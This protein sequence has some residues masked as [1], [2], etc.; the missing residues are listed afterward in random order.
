MTARISGRRRVS[1]LR[2]L[3]CGFF[4]EQYPRYDTLWEGLSRLGF[5]Q[6]IDLREKHVLN[7]KY[8]EGTR[9]EAGRNS[10]HGIARR[11]RTFLRL[12]RY[13]ISIS[14]AAR[15]KKADVIF[16]FSDNHFLAICLG[17]LK[18]FH[19]A[20]VY[21][22]L[23]DPIYLAAKRNSRG[24]FKIVESYVLEFLASRLADRLLC[25][26][27]ECATY[28]RDQYRV[29][30]DKLSVVPDG[31]QGIWFDEPA[32]IGH[33]THRPRRVLYWGMFLPH[34]GLDMILDA[35][36]ELRDENIEF[37]FCGTGDK[38]EWLKEEIRRRNL[39]NVVFKGFIPT[40]REL[41]HI[42]NGVDVTLGALRDVPALKLAPLNR[43]RQAMARGKPVITI[44]TRQQEDFY[45]T[46]TT[47]FP[48]LI[49]IEPDVESLVRAIVD[50]VNSPE[51]AERIGNIAR[52]T[53]RRLHGI[54]AITSALGKSFEKALEV[55][56]RAEGD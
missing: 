28:Y 32:S 14:Q 1:D 39:D 42:I 38:E 2:V 47:P 31:V 21:F 5:Q 51:K 12:C 3:V 16:V 54:E 17:M 30:D 29:R 11:T 18:F 8:M 23:F 9:S 53:A 49:L 4:L 48:P 43:V 46:K 34:H 6:L 45:Q 24:R 41:I 37:I 40:T 56:R 55:G 25:F 52:S 20:W 36:E 33:E 19:S 26:T 44:W 13:A 22:D 7:H 35:A 27:P 10:F 15:H 50:I